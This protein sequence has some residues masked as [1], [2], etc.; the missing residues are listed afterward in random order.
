MGGN[1]QRVRGQSSWTTLTPP[2]PSIRRPALTRDGNIAAAALICT[3]DIALW[4]RALHEG[5]TRPLYRSPS[6]PPWVTKGARMGHP[7]HHLLP[8]ISGSSVRI[9][10]TLTV[11]KENK[12]A[13]LKAT[14]VQ[15]YDTPTD[16]LTGV[17]CRATSIAK[18]YDIG[19]E[20]NS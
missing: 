2:P 8:P 20:K 14:L 17:K 4:G 16:R 3:P 10:M 6:L 11:E 12:L 7:F 18:K 13:I 19:M 15:N 9:P 5:S 1:K